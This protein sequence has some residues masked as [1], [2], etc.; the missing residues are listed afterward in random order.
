M[1]EKK[2]KKM[3][4]DESLDHVT[5]GHSPKPTIYKFRCKNSDCLREFESPASYAKCPSCGSAA[6]RIEE[7]R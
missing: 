1:D 5:G 7:S 4:D 2:K 3:I 6:D